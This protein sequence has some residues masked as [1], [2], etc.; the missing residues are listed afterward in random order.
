MVA[1]RRLSTYIYDDDYARADYHY[2]NNARADY[3]YLNNARADYHY[4][5]FNLL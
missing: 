3:H 1:N 2:L 4:L 5:N